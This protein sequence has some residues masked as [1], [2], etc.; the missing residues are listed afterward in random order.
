MKVFKQP[1]HGLETI[2]TGES[3]ENLKKY[4]DKLQSFAERLKLGHLISEQLIKPKPNL[5]NM[6][7]H[8]EK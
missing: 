8:F 2:G 6:K 1:V 4:E 3:V 5:K 7:F